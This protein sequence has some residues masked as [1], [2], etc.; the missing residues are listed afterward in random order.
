LAAAAVQVAGAAVAAAEV[1]LL[2]AL[3]PHRQPMKR[4]VQHRRRV[5]ALPKPGREVQLQPR[6]PPHPKPNWRWH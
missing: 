5:A 6:R 3:R 4:V 1:V 2:A